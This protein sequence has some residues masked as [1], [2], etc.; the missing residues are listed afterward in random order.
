VSTPVPSAFIS[1]SRE[2]SEFA[3]RLAQ[4]LKAAGAQVWLDQIDI[5]PGRSWDNAV[6]DALLDAPQMLV[7]LSPS[8]ARS[9]NVRN[10]ISFALEQGKIVV[11]VLYRDCVVPLRLQRTQRIDFRADYAAGLAHLLDHLRVV[12]P[13]PAVL[14]KAAEE[15]AQRHAAWQAREAEALRLRDLAHQREE[16]ER[17]QAQEADRKAREADE[18]RQKQEANELAVR[19]LSR[20]QAAERQAKDRAEIQAREAEAQ[21]QREQKAQRLRD[22]DA[23]SIR[24]AQ[25]Q[26][27]LD[28]ER[29]R[30]HQLE[31]QEQRPKTETA[32]QQAHAPQLFTWVAVEP[33][34]GSDDSMAKSQAFMEN[35]Q[36]WMIAAAIG[37]ICLLIWL[38]ILWASSSPDAI[39]Q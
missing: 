15:D 25:A 21:R 33:A 14:G 31:A 24:R 8:A 9:E 38:V 10:E 28:E 11:P 26:K 34:D 16:A 4:D 22:A 12:D 29:E 23:A 36:P 19:D 27:K 6:E 1:Y 30:L 7:V 32:Q 3:L 37:V 18:L 35:I 13:D 20:K 2:D 39:Q 17:Q 5:K